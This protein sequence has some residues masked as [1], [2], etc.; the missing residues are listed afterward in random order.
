MNH[1]VEEIL[2]FNWIYSTVSNPFKFNYFQDKIVPDTINYLVIE[3]LEASQEP[4]TIFKRLLS[5]M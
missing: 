3:G 2:D 5:W 1:V 4:K